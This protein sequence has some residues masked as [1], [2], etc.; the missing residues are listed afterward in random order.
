VFAP[1]DTF[2]I[3]SGNVGEHLFVI[4]LPFADAVGFPKQ[5]T[6]LLSVCTTVVKCD[7]TCVLDVGDHPFIRHE[8][9]VAYNHARLHSHQDL[10]ERE[11]KGVFRKGT[12]IEGAV[13]KRIFEGL[14]NSPR[15]PNYIIDAF[16]E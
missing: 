15:T 2:F 14:R 3:E 10:I 8:S 13:L 4:A 16:L 1:G 9:Y 7:R 11:Q 12:P 6:V 5:S